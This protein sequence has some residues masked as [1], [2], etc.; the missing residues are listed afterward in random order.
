MSITIPEFRDRFP[1]FSD[2]VEYPDDRIQMFLND[3]LCTIGSDPSRWCSECKYDLALSY[4][5]AHLLA[6]G[7]GSESGNSGAVSGTPTTKTAGGVSV[8]Y[9]SMSSS[10][11]G[12]S[13]GEQLYS[14]TIYGQRYLQIRSSCFVSILTANHL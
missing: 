2:P 9:S 12:M 8:S 14:S 11:G 6:L 10:S 4:L 1:E 3:A 5:T 13:Y 7:T